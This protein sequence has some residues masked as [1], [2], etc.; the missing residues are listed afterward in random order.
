MSQTD[1]PSLR[2]AELL[3]SLSLAI[4]LGLGQPMENLLRTCLLAI[5]LGKKLRVSEQDLVDIYYLALIRQLGCTTYADEAVTGFEGDIAVNSWA[6]TTNQ[7]HPTEFVH[8]PLQHVAQ[9]M[10]SQCLD[11]QSGL[12]SR[13]QK[14]LWQIHERWDGEGSPNKLKGEAILLPLRVVRIAQDAEICNRLDGTETTRALLRQ[15]AGVI[16][17]PQIVECFCQYADHLFEEARG[18]SLWEAVLAAEPGESRYISQTSLDDV[19]RAVADFV[20]L[21]LRSPTGHSRKVAELAADAAKRCDLPETDVIAIR[22]AGFLHD[23]GRIGISNT[24]WHKPGPLSEVEWELVRLHPYYTERVLAR[25]KGLGQVRIIAAQLHERLDG[26]GY[27]RGLPAS[28][29][30]MSVR[31]LAA[32]DV[33]HAL[34]ERREHRPAKLPKVAAEEL[35]RQVREGLLDDTAVHAVLM[36]AGHRLRSRRHERVAGLSDREIEVLRLVAHGHSNRQMAR[37]L[38][39]SKSTIHH[40]IQHIYTKLGVSTRTAVTVFAMQHSLLDD[41]EDAQK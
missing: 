28:K 37:L 20:D 26:S 35:R 8:A 33:Y 16:Y 36:A 31:I 1:I 34:T 23:L 7:E 4:D 21:K 40:H 9:K 29:L 11:G 27:Y 12:G 22:Q 14:A 13:I 39:V 10:M 38:C 5:G 2:F 25:L 30:P 6:L 17:D 15:R 32:A 41:R 24:I 18:S 19:L 3:A